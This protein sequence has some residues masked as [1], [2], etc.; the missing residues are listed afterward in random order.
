MK[1]ALELVM[2]ATIKA[3]EEAIRKALEKQREEAEK[4]E[5]TLKYCEKLGEEMERKAEK[6]QMPTASMRFDYFHRPITSTCKDYADGRLSYRGYDEAVDFE[7][8]AEWFAQYCFTIEIK[9]FDFWRYG[10]GVCNG[11]EIV[12]SPNPECVK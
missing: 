3:E 12:I 9:K 2:T 7:L 1:C 5:R 10:C 6:G 8:M 11:Y 4:R